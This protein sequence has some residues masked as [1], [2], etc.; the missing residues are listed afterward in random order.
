MWLG[1]CT[2]GSPASISICLISFTLRWCWRLR[3]C[4]SALFRVRTDSRAP[5]KSM[6]GRDV[7]K[8]KPAAYERTVSIREL[9]LEMYP[10]TQPNA[11][12]KK[13][14]ENHPNL[15][16]PPIRTTWSITALLHFHLW[17]IS[18]QQ[19]TVPAPPPQS[20]IYSAHV[21]ALF[22]KPIPVTIGLVIT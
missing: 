9:V 19:S 15:F 16:L 11:L 5:A 20:C 13:K 22:L 14:K 12:P 2:T 7:V 6:G 4:P 10:P 21:A 18:T 1:Q 8:I 17:V 3:T